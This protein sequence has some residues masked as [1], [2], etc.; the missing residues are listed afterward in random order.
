MPI[1]N[2]LA[3]LTQLGARTALHIALPPRPDGGP[4]LIDSESSH[5]GILLSA[6]KEQ[7]GDALYTHHYI[8]PHRY[9]EDPSAGTVPAG[10]RPVTIAG[11]PCYSNQQP[12]TGTSLYSDG[13][14]QT[15]EIAGLEYQAAEA[16]M[17]KGP[18]RILARVPNPQ[19]SYRAEMYRAAIGV[20][21]ASDG[22]TQYITAH[23]R[24]THECSD[25]D[26]R[27][28]VCDQVQYKRVATEWIPSHRLEME[29][30][31]VR[32]REQIRRGSR[33]TCQDGHA[34]TRAG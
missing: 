23:R 31:K 34:R 15:V 14:L 33:P 32:E 10:Y 25:A 3:I 4:N 5:D 8:A 6:R 12:P 24:P 26:I 28:K 19:Q 13:T 30:R 11:I 22:D 21:I 29:A 9:H 18:L 2:Y 17:T 20:A 27:H 7:M 16:A 1:R